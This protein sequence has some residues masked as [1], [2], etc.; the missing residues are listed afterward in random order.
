MGRGSQ[1]PPG[2]ASSQHLA[3]AHHVHGGA[4]ELGHIVQEVPEDQH[5]LL[6]DAQHPRRAA[7]D[8]GPPP[9]RQE[10][11]RSHPASRQHSHR[12]RGRL[13]WTLLQKG[14][15]MTMTLCLVWIHSDQLSEIKRH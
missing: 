3:G 15:T 12:Y 11:R 2:E 1:D 9:D 4:P 10:P 14:E 7:P 5:G 6:L 13:L 8:R